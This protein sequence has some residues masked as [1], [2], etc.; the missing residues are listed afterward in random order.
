VSVLR[1]LT[2]LDHDE[3]VCTGVDGALPPAKVVRRMIDAEGL[4]R[5]YQIQTRRQSSSARPL[6]ECHDVIQ[7]SLPLL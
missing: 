1:S 2:S 4:D 3:G 7:L 5:G 6:P